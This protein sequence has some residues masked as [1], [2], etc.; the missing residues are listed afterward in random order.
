MQTHILKCDRQTQASSAN[1]ERPRWICPPK[2]I[3]HERG[4]TWSKSHTV[5]AN[6]H[7]DGL[8]ISAH[9]DINRTSFTMLDRVEDEI[10][11]YAV[12]PSCV[13]LN[14]DGLR[15]GDDSQV[16]SLGQR[17]GPGRLHGSIK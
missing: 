15:W 17:E 14:P 2:S 8:V 16:T 5:V 7:R 1:G 4:F 12:N 9:G 3:E 13:Q 11:K 10:A 6:R